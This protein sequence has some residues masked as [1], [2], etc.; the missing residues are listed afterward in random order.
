MAVR[1]LQ[2]ITPR[3]HH[4]HIFS[5]FF[6]PSLSLSTLHSPGDLFFSSFPSS[7]S[8]SRL[9]L[10]QF[11]SNLPPPTRS[12]EIR[13]LLR[14]SATS[15]TLAQRIGKSLRRPG[16]ASKARVYCDVNVIRPK[17]YWDY[18][19]LTVQWGYGFFY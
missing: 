11:G 8:Q 1:P 17:E 13:R 7:T 16:A 15:E 5:I 19:S 12:S 18:E 9:F 4:Q 14:P 10:R 2:F 6:L 3:N